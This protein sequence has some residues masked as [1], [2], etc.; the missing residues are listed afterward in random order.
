MVLRPQQDKY[1]Y[2]MCC[3][4]GTYVILSFDFHPNKE[5]HRSE[6]RVTPLLRHSRVF[7][8]FGT[9]KAINKS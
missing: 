7:F 8:G 3:G 6:S 2:D 1:V 9:N 4:G 5:N